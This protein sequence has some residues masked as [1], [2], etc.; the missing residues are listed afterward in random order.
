MLLL[1]SLL[2]L[3]LLLLCCVSVLDPLNYETSGYCLQLFLLFVVCFYLFIS[4]D[5]STVQFL[6]LIS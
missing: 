3:T 4:Q 2:L 6:I 5:N 1:A